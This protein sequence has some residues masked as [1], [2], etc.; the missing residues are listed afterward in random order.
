MGEHEQAIA[1]LDDLLRVERTNEAAAMN[2]DVL[3]RALDEMRAR[4]LLGRTEREV[5][6]SAIV[7]EG[8]L[9]RKGKS[10]APEAMGKNVQMVRYATGLAEMFVGFDAAPTARWLMLVLPSPEKAA[11]KR[12]NVFQVTVVGKDGKREPANYA[13]GITLTFLREAIGAP[14]TQASELYA[15]LLGGAKEVEWGGARV[16]FGSV[17]R[18]DKPKE[19]M[20]G[21]IVE[22]AS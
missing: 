7:Q 14:M 16:R 8:Q 3:A 18:P 21:L 13:T 6:A 4:R 22:I 17:P 20:H 1:V 9:K 11:K 5:E 12:D 15:R 19:E 10:D 2:R